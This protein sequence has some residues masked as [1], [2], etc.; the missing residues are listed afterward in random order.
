[1]IVDLYNRYFSLY[2]LLCV[3]SR[4]ITLD[5]LPAH[6]AN[7]A[8]DQGYKFSEEYEVLYDVTVLAKYQKW[9]GT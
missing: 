9:L 5:N 3:S 7:M 1:M 2:P 6:F 8:A 4:K